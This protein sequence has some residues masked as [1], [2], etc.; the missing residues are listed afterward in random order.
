MVDTSGSINDRALATVYSEIKG[1]LEQYDGKLVGRLGFFDEESTE[2]V[3]MSTVD[4]LLSIVP[5]GGG[6]TNFYAA[7]SS[8]EK[9][10]PSCII[11]FTDAE[12]EFPPEEYARDVPVM[13]IINGSNN[14]APWG[15]TIN[16][17]EG[18]F[19]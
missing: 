4:D 7:F 17:R 18:D 12:G 1:A 14:S 3:P 16:L 6:G 15:K 8:L 19:Y 5:V 2:P 13:W 11:I 9:E 10:L